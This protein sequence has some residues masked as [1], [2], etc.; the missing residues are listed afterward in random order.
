MRPCPDAGSAARIRPT[1]QCAVAGVSGCKKEATKA[2]EGGRSYAR[3]RAYRW[4][5]PGNLHQTGRVF[6]HLWQAS[7]AHG[8]CIRRTDRIFMEPE[9][10]VRPES[11]H[12]TR[13]SSINLVARPDRPRSD[14]SSASAGATQL[15]FVQ[16]ALHDLQTPVA[17][18]DLSMKLLADDL[19]GAGPDALATLRGAERAVRRIQQYIDHLVTSERSGSLRPRRERVDLVSL[20]KDIVADYSPHAATTG[21]AFGLDVSGAQN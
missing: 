15:E 18:L 1:D 2:S 17:V 8:S 6:P 5:D 4:P 13:V 10:E 9:P 11:T 16:L 14:R 21:V 12:P 3:I 20:L 7:P 19:A